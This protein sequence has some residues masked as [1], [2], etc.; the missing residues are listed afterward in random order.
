MLKSEIV[1]KHGFLGKTAKER[2]DRAIMS[3]RKQYSKG[4][5][6]GVQVL[7]S[8]FIAFAVIGAFVFVTQ[9]RAMP[10][11]QPAG[12]IAQQEYVLILITIGLGVF[13]VIPVFI[14]L[15]WIAIRYRAGN[16]K[17]KYD[18]EFASHRGFEALWWGIPCVIIFALA[19]ITSI[20]THA[21]DPYKPLDSAVKP[22]EVQVVAMEWKWLFIYKDKGVAT[23]NYLN[24]PEKT[25]INFTI[26]ADSPMNSIW[27]PALT[28][29]VYAMSGMS[30]KL[31]FMADKTGTFNG[32][33]ANI[34]G[35][36]YADMTFKVNSLSSVDFE[37]WVKTSAE[38]PTALSVVTYKEL[39]QPAKSDQKTYALADPALYN[40]IID[41]YMA[42]ATSQP[43]NK[44]DGSDSG[45]HHMEG[46]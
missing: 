25:P 6:R 28:G 1:L 13:V 40:R 23:V 26:T 4:L 15:F 30:T 17:A 21:L 22:V 43:K 2:Y 5:K 46:M 38:S 41:K 16:K 19:I 12:T 3:N 29:Q 34:S 20:A 42:P 14:L 32:T 27:I 39:A 31:H 11:L 18:P 8:C 37:N 36:G 35:E 44:Q 33:T 45:A 24:I 10:V 9:G 7:V